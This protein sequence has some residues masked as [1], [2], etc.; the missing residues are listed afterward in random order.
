MRPSPLICATRARIDEGRTRPPGRRSSMTRDPSAVR[1][2]ESGHLAYFESVGSGRLAETDTPVDVRAYVSGVRLPLFNVA[3]APGRTARLASIGW[4]ADRF[5]DLRLPHLWWL[6]PSNDRRT[7]RSRLERAGYTLWEE[8]IGMSLDPSGRRASVPR[9]SGLKIHEATTGLAV[10][11]FAQTFTEGTFERD[12]DAA[13]AIARRFAS[14]RRQRETVL[15]VGYL[16]GHPVA[17]SAGFLHDGLIG[18][19]A[20]A[21]LPRF[22]HQG[23]GAAMTDEI[24]E[25]GWSVGIRRA[26]LVASPGGT[27][28]YARMG[29]VACCRLLA[30][31]REPKPRADGRKSGRG[32]G[33]DPRPSR[34]RSPG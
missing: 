1:D 34:L 23:I 10:R 25:R 28:L 8:S 9:P 27:S 26:V 16:G 14:L 11:D 20:V 19:H 5:G 13:D 21:T 7:L 17:T 33:I 24:L 12:P 4:V 3:F 32:P 6:L 29:F 22:R 2:V 15:L 18:V 31:L 30:Y